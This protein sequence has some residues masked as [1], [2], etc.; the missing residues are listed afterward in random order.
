MSIQKNVTDVLIGNGAAATAVGVAMNDAA[1]GQ[2]GIIGKDMLAIE[3]STGTIG[4]D[5]QI[6]IA[7]KLA[8]GTFNF[9][10]IIYS[11]LFSTTCI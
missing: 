9:V 3:A 6:F 2:L 1:A 7:N 5:P 8:D 10:L 11:C 4:I